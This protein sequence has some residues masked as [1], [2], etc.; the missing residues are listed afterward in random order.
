MSAPAAPAT[1]RTRPTAGEL[2]SLTERAGAL[3]AVR[4]GFLVVVLAF[5]LLLP[6]ELTASRAELTIGSLAYLSLLLV[7]WLVWGRSTRGAV[8]IIGGTLLLDGIFLAWAVSSTGGT[9]SPLWFLVFANVVAVTLLGSYRTGLKIS[10]WHVL[11]FLVFLYAQAADLF[12]IREGLPSALPGGADFVP[13]TIVRVGAI[14]A[15]A[16]GAAACAAVRERELRA[17]KVD[18]EE[19]SEMVA[20]LDRRPAA[21]EIPEILLDAL[22]R[23]FGFGRSVVLASPEGDL[24]VIAHRGIGEVPDVASGID[25]AVERAWRQR[26]TQ[27]VRELDPAADPRLSALLPGARNV[28]VVPFQVEGGNRLG[29]VA[30]EYPDR[31]HTIRRWRVTIVEQFAA[32]AALSLQNAWL[33]EQLERR[34]AENRA[35]QQQLVAQNLGLELQV[36]ERT[37][38]LRQSLEHLRVTDEQRRLLLARLVHV[39]EDERERLAGDIHDDPVQKLIAASMWLQL[40]RRDVSDPKHFEAIE[41]ILGV[42]GDAIGSLRT[43]TFRLRPSVLDEEGLAP[44]LREFLDSLEADFDHAVEDRLE[45]EPASELRVVLYRMAQEA[46]NN[47]HK[48]ANAKM[49]HVL[50]EH[51]RGGYL[52]RINDDGVGFTAPA[53]M[54]SERGHLGLSSMRERAAMAGGTCRLESLPGAGTT[55]EFWVPHPRVSEQANEQAREPAAGDVRRTAVPA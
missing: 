41:T 36:E 40:L 1:S 38:D 33:R 39:E 50:L 4:C 51:R 49:V 27:L 9:Q 16:L 46:L 17:Q 2:V 8:A 30:L 37:R 55:V 21:S 35:L 32:H 44:A 53:S 3:G 31:R 6:E 24:A 13:S 25:R 15:V 20:E 18:L 12:P 43:L 14:V 22:G 34:Y 47:V 10:A 7:P 26:R 29:I 52:V 23:A 5:A 19:L 11:L 42:I 45:H 28:L 54:R 48:H